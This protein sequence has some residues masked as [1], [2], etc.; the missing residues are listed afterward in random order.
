MSQWKILSICLIVLLWTGLAHAAT[1]A[2]EPDSFP[3]G[4]GIRTAFPGVTL[5][6]QG[7]P[8]SEVHAVDGF[9][10]FNGK[11]LATYSTIICWRLSQQVGMV[12]DLCPLKDLDVT[13]IDTATVKLKG[14]VPLSLVT[15]DVFNCTTAGRDG[16][17][18]LVLKFDTQAVVAALGDIS[19]RE[20]RVLKLTGKLQGEFGGE[21]IAG[22]DIVVIWDK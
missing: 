18:D 4:T 2:I 11:N 12:E 13:Q 10:A 16:R 7:K 19:H 22:E 6:V 15:K 3:E 17:M 5:S 8:A 21:P 20:V 14:I 9:S 1:L